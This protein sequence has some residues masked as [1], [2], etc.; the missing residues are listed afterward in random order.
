[1][2]SGF[3]KTKFHIPALRADTLSRSK[4]VE[5]LN[6]S[7][8]G[9]LSLIVAPAGYGK[10]TL[11]VE[12]LNTL[13]KGKEKFSFADCAWLSLSGD[14]NS[15][16]RFLGYLIE[17]VRTV[18]PGFGVEIHESLSLSQDPNIEA[19]TFEL[20]NEFVESDKKHLLVFDDIHRID[21]PKIFKIIELLIEHIPVNVHIVITS[22]ND[23]P[24][25]LARWRTKGWLFEF[26]SDKLRFSSKETVLY[27]Q[28]SVGLDL[29]EEIIK[30]LED[31]TEGWPAGL[32]LAALA[33][34]DTRVPGNFSK[35]VLGDSREIA[36]YFL[37]EVLARQPEHIRDFLYQTS[38]LEQFSS[39]LCEALL[40]STGVSPKEIL[41]GLEK[42]DLFIVSL[43]NQRQ[44]YR[45]HHLFSELLLDRLKRYYSASDVQSL[46]LRAATWHKEQENINL[47]LEH[48][49]E[50]QDFD[51]AADVISSISVGNLWDNEIGNLILKWGG[52]I[53]EVVT[54]NHPQV[55][56]RIAIVMLILG[57]YPELSKVVPLIQ[58]DPSLELEN[59]VLDGIFLRAD[60]KISEALDLFLSVEQKIEDDHSVWSYFCQ[61]QIIMCYL[62]LGKLDLAQDRA[63]KLYDLVHEGQ[64]VSDTLLLQATHLISNIMVLRGELFQSQKL[65]EKELRSLQINKNYHPLQGLL[66]SVLGVIYYYWNELEAAAENFKL[67]LTWGERSG[68]VDVLS[69]AHVGL[70]SILLARQDE[71][72]LDHIL[73]AYSGYRP[74]FMEMQGNAEEAYARLKLKDV[75]SAVRW[76]DSSGLSLND[77]AEPSSDNLY[78][79]LLEIRV[80][81]LHALGETKALLGLL[82]FVDKL[83]SQAVESQNLLNEIESLAVKAMIFH[84]AGNPRDAVHVIQKALEKSSASGVIQIFLLWGETMKNLLQNALPYGKHTILI[85][86]LLI[87]FDN[88]PESQSSRSLPETKLV[89]PLTSRE[90]EV[91]QLIAEGL[92]NKKIQKTLNIS[93]NT[94]RTHIRNTYRKLDVGSRTQAVRRARE[95]GLL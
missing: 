93:Q 2:A 4:L 10:T 95:L 40:P 62:V 21:D 23:P 73:L 16:D 94:V 44:W 67:A 1:M 11:V 20:I 51:G 29:S 58:D 48:Y 27:F 84:L 66:Y 80:E 50:A 64:I 63:Q 41:D 28:V 61:H 30:D 85:N 17:S 79:I 88:V 3:P 49:F 92:S 69:G 5:S 36:D 39:S 68:I 56:V 86:R 60:G 25:S 91:L 33:L 77:M 46:H 12:W 74:S 54:K 81:E 55:L 8:E 9:R 76:A 43:D 32:K 15:G 87:A 52:K 47:S 24:L 7:L 59:K 13:Q 83:I 34:K 89:E 57:K 6:E 18:H 72:A 42:S 90:Q 26:R 45:Y 75:Q 22:R 53:P 35:I 19:V 65:L 37:E 71:R 70:G 14:E 38:I 78:R 31:R 82:P